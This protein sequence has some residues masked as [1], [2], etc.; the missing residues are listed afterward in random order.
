MTKVLLDFDGVVFCNKQIHQYVE[1]RSVEF[2]KHR[3]KLSDIEAKKTNKKS[4][5]THGHTCLGFE[6]ANGELLQDYNNFVFDTNIP[7][8]AVN[9]NDQ[10]RM[11]RIIDIKN[12]RNL[13]IYVCTNATLDYCVNIMNKMKLPF[14]YLFS[15]QYIFTSDTLNAM[16]P[17]QI[18]FDKVSENVSHEIAFFDDSMMNIN[19]A[20]RNDWD[21]YYITHE[22]QLFDK[23]KY[24]KD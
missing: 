23:L 18:F 8:D 1:H 14:D 5:K 17:T 10:K 2:V 13:D 11:K 24:F 12:D 16:K 19:S 6:D 22:N 7:Y 3:W 15:T 21:S 4:Y 9:Q 20:A